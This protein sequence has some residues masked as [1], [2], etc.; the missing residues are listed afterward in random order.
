MWMFFTLYNMCSIAIKENICN[1]G[2]AFEVI[3]HTSKLNVDL[4]KLKHVLNCGQYQMN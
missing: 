3:K 1:K 4:K 2:W